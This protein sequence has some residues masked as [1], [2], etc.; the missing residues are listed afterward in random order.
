M[1]GVAVGAAIIIAKHD[2]GD[3]NFQS[4]DFGA[5]QVAI[6]VRKPLSLT[7]FK[8]LMDLHKNRAVRGT[9]PTARMINS[10][11]FT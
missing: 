10:L 7:I 6:I 3:G 11:A 9:T 1:N 5:K 8:R 4:P 2:K